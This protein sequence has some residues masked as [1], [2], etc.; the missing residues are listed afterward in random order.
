MNPC[1]VCTLNFNSEEFLLPCGCMICKDCVFSWC[2]ALNNTSLD[3]PE[4]FYFC[5]N[6]NCKEKISK[7]WFYENME[8][9]CLKKFDKILLKKYLNFS[10]DILKCPKS[11]CP[12]A[13]YIDYSHRICQERLQCELCGEKWINKVKEESHFNI[14]NYLKEELTELRIKVLCRPCYHCKRY[15]YRYTGCNHITCTCQKQFCYSCLGD[16]QTHNISD[17]ENKDITVSSIIL[18]LVFAI[19]F[20]TSLSFYYF[21]AFLYYLFNGILYNLIAIGVTLYTVISSY[22]YYKGMT[23]RQSRLSEKY[24]YHYKILFTL[25]IILSIDFTYKA[26]T[27]YEIIFYSFKVFIV[28]AFIILVGLGIFASA[29]IIKNLKTWFTK[30]KVT[31]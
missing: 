9:H 3:R 22:L 30:R 25:L 2:E 18:F 12:Y 29:I 21:R 6:D 31:G 14:I 20:K 7:Q 26:I 10:P 27:S 28:E 19:I 5:P 24:Y 11:S 1:L 13:G 17:C 8:P 4:E 23:M 15:I 16:W